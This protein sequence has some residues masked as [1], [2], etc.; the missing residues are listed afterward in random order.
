MKQTCRLAGGSIVTESKCSEIIC[1]VVSIGLVFDNDVGE[2]GESV[3]VNPPDK[4]AE[5][6]VLDEVGGTFNVLTCL[7][8][9]LGERE[10]LAQF[11][12]CVK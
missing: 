8:K 4:P 11:A 3:I 7:S 6:V 1:D 2:S 5:V 12:S 10:V 9:V